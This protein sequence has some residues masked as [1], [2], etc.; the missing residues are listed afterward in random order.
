MNDGDE[1]VRARTLTRAYIRIKNIKYKYNFD[2]HTTMVSP[3]MKA[4]PLDAK[5]TAIIAMS[6][7]RPI[8]FSGMASRNTSS[9]RPAPSL[10]MPAVS[11]IGPERKRDREREK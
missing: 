5:Y 4:P 11:P 9:L 3:E 2:E 7:L 1:L 10:A 6:H 8:R